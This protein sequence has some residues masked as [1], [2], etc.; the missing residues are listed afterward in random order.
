MRQF[1]DSE[2]SKYTSEI[3][4][5]KVIFALKELNATVIALES[6]CSGIESR[7]ILIQ[8]ENMDL[9]EALFWLELNPDKTPADWAR[10]QQVK[11]KL[12]EAR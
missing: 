10:Y 3:D 7:L 4:Q 6:R 9:R 11:D 12:R 1:Q 5:Q 8:S 2:F